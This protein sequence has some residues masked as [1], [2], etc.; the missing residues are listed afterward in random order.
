MKGKGYGS[1][2]KGKKKMKSGKKAAIGYDD[3]GSYSSLPGYSAHTYRSPWAKGPHHP[4][5]GC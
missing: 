4:R 3:T 5:P 1:H 2:S